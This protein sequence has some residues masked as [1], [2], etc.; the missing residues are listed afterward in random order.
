MS[1]NETIILNIAISTVL[2]FL[3][4]G[5]ML[6]SH[7]RRGM[8]SLSFLFLF[9]ATEYL[10]RAVQAGMI[11][12]GQS[13]GLTLE[14]ASDSGTNVCLL[15]TAFVLLQYARDT[16]NQAIRDAL[17]I[18]GGGL[19]S[20]LNWA[21]ASQRF[22][23][24]LIVLPFVPFTI[25]MS[26]LLGRTIG[27]ASASTFETWH[28]LPD[29]LGSVIPLLLFALGASLNLDH[30]FSARGTLF[31]GLSYAAIHVLY[32]IQPWIHAANL[33]SWLFALAIPLK[34][35]FFVGALTAIRN[36]LSRG[37]RRVRQLM[38]AIGSTYVHF[39][40]NCGLDLMVERIRDCISENLLGQVRIW[41]DVGFRCPVW[42]KDPEHPAPYHSMRCLELRSGN[43]YIGRLELW[44]PAFEADMVVDMHKHVLAQGLGDFVLQA[45]RLDLQSL[46]TKIAE[47]D[48]DENWIR[49]LQRTIFPLGLHLRAA[50]ISETAF[51]ESPNPRSFVSLF[52]QLTCETSNSSRQP[53]GIE[54]FPMLGRDCA[55][56]LLVVPLDASFQDQGLI[57]ECENTYFGEPQRGNLRSQLDELSQT[58]P[59]RGFLENIRDIAKRC[60]R[61]GEFGSSLID[62]MCRFRLGVHSLKNDLYEGVSALDV[63]MK[64]IPPE[65][66][67]SDLVQALTIARNRMVEVQGQLSTY[68]TPVKEL[69]RS[70]LKDVLDTLSR[71]K[72]SVHIHLEW[73]N[74]DGEDI[75]VALPRNTLLCI[76]SNLCDNTHDAGGTCVLITVKREVEYVRLLYADDAGGVKA[77]PTSLFEFSRRDGRRGYGLPSSR[78]FLRTHGGSIR[79][80]EAVAE[81]HQGHKV[82][83]EFE[84]H[85]PLPFMI[86]DNANVAAAR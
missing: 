77:N 41:L 71:R 44:L 38:E 11:G 85:L 48:S 13:L 60:A 59:W 61:N 68:V 37:S 49:T 74:I 21:A 67:G 17:R 33:E 70:F 1:N 27:I 15:L 83:A 50:R 54:V 22:P 79:L 23:P 57:F 81:W 16:G 6:V 62:H 46:L 82:G 58:T 43:L 25:Q 40:S 29:G 32:A 73:D 7:L 35:I 9:Y 28:R 26:L 52:S 8:V 75:L 78:R 3:M 84:L 19:Q 2:F 64:V 24:F 34:L 10:G 14:F 56:R 65:Q 30:G 55:H 53:D 31:A 47:T 72:G 42:P 39:P 45:V 66:S 63:E 18:S 51:P 86:E 20:I 69:P 12:G 5:M 4:I 36:G 76:L 80:K